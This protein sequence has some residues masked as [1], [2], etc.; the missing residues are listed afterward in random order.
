MTDELPIVSTPVLTH[1][2]RC[3][4]CCRFF[5]WRRWCALGGA[6]LF[7]T[8]VGWVIWERWCLDILH[9]LHVCWHPLLCH[10]PQRIPSTALRFPTRNMHLKRTR[11]VHHQ[12]CVLESF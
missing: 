3:I 8:M 5:C 10:V 2:R 9:L 7:L 4:C 6:L 1:S 12:H 11:R